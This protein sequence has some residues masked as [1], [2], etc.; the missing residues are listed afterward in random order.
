MPEVRVSM[1]ADD[2]AIWAS[3]KYKEEA[4]RMV[5]RAVN[6]IAG[7]SE[8]WLMTLNVEKCEVALFTLDNNELDYK[9]EIKINDKQFTF[10]HYPTFLGVTYDRRLAFTE[11][12]RRTCEKVRKRI[13]ILRAVA[14]TDWGFDKKILKTTYTSLCR[15]ILEYG[16]PAWMP[17]T[18]KTDMETIEKVQLEAARVITGL[19]K[20][21]PTEALLIEAEL[22]TS[23][24][25]YLSSWIISFKSS[26]SFHC[27][28]F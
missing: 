25:R 8:R 21:T 14:G 13:S 9:P 23:L 6:A 28:E 16:A 4:T 17:W 5:Q 26:T 12:I 18:S 3:H 20:S 11:H 19:T 1:F 24:F 15:S 27:Y 22:P 7:W 2:L 10:N